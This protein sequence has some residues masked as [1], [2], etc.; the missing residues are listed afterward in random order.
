[1]TY[2]LAFFTVLFIGFGI[3]LVNTKHRLGQQLSDYRSRVAWGVI[4]IGI[5]TVLLLAAVRTY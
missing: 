4:L 2:L 5:G 1:M 3:T